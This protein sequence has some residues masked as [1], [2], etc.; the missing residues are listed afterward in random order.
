MLLHSRSSGTAYVG[1]GPGRRGATG[2]LGVGVK[3]REALARDFNI[4]SH[5][6]MLKLISFTGFT[7]R[8]LSL[9]FVAAAV[10]T[11]VGGTLTHSLSLPPSL[12]HSLLPLSPL[13]LSPSNDGDGSSGGTSLPLFWQLRAPRCIL[14][15]FFSFF[16]FFFL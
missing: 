15:P 4:R 5:D 1:G 11:T 7:L 10:M 3:E 6:L 13:S 8:P 16:L 12:P 2:G 14:F 9:Y